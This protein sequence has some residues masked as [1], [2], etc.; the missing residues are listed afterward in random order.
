MLAFST[1]WNSSR[2]KSG[3]DMLQEILDMGFKK[4]E[5][6]HGVRLPLMPGILE[7]REKGAVEITSLHNFCPLP[8]EITRAS[9]NCYEFSSHRSTDRERAVRLTKQT[10]DYA[11][12]LGAS[13]MVLH[14]GTVRT[15]KNSTSDLIKMTQEGKLYSREYVRQKLAMVKERESKGAFYLQRVEECLKPILE[16][17]QEKSV[18]LGIEC[19]DRYEEIPAEREIPALLDRLGAMTGYWHD[20]GHAQIKHNL[21]FFN[22]KEWLSKMAPRLLGCHL[23]DVEWPNDDHRPPFTGE[24]DFEG[25]MRFLPKNTYFVLEMNP[26]RSRNDILTAAER[27]N[28][29]FGA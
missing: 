26:K 23:H 27:W 14:L 5:L 25:F 9:P 10:I 8:V 18:M 22:H 1:C 29:L 7:M 20:F 24:I 13:K 11:H 17:A 2:H 15:L 19:R 12:R 3:A 21:G 4:V 16:Y 28:N 6:G